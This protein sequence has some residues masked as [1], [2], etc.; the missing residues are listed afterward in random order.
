MRFLIATILIGISLS[1][2]ASELTAVKT[3]SIYKAFTPEEKVNHIVWLQVDGDQGLGALDAQDLRKYGGVYLSRPFQPFEEYIFNRGF[4][5]ALAVQLD[6]N[7]NPSPGD[8]ENLPTLNTLSSIRD[9]NLLHEYF[10]F[11]KVISKSFGISH[12]VLPLAKDTVS[13]HGRLMAKMEAHDPD[14]FISP[15]RLEFDLIKKKKEFKSLF[16]GADF[17]VLSGEELSRAEKAIR[18]HAEHANF[19]RA[20]NTIKS[21]ITIKYSSHDQLVKRKLPNKLAVEISRASIVPL[22]R[23]PGI[24]PLSSDTL[25]L[26]TDDPAGF[27][28]KMLA[29][30]AYLITS[31]SGIR[32]SH[33]PVI[34]DNQYFSQNLN[35]FEGR[36]IIY[37]GGFT[38]GIKY[39]DEIDA[40]LFT[41]VENE[42]YSYLL[43]QLLFGSADATGIM[44]MAVSKLASYSNEPITGKR[45][46]GYAP[47]E[48]SGLTKISR[49]E[50][51]SIV[52]EAIET[53]STPGCQIAVAIDGSIVLEEGY[54]YLTYDS[55]IR[56][57]KNT[58]Y[59]LASVT[60]VM[61][62]LL[63]VMKLYEDN[64]INLDADLSTYL[65]QYAGS[66]K[67]DITIRQILSHNAGLISYVPFW[68]RALGGAD[69]M[70]TF[71][72]ETEEDELNDK[73][74]YGMKPTP[75]L[76]DSLKNWIVSSPVLDYDSVPQYRYSDIG[77]MILHQVVEAITSEPME[78]YLT[79]NFYSKLGLS[80]LGFNPREKGVNLFEVAPTEYDY[81]FREE[82]VWGEVHDRNA[83]VFGGVAGHAGL[84][85]NSHDLLVLLQMIAQNGE[86]DGEQLLKPSTIHYFNDQYFPGNR[87]A[88]GWDKKG[89]KV[90][91]ASENA[92]FSSFGHTGFTGTLVWVDPEFDLVFVFLSNRIYPNANNY[93]LIQKDIRTRVQDVVYE[94]IL[95]KWIN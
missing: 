17:W 57:D 63:A 86:Y 11:L 74:S 9:E 61:G 67:S 52:Q 41:S 70:E 76:R 1:S 93:K 75:A 33:A 26:V 40:A 87:R 49:E 84:F 43:P 46:L 7:L 94:A 71:Y 21:S 12:L 20:E 23:Q 16:E 15:S 56:A 59:D 79:T 82:Q 8:L 73:R 13:A 69:M 28:A 88:L 37:L 29:R 58:M 68:K 36:S 95:S 72:Y 4:I 55:L 42:L 3:D 14:Y 39:G 6:E 81:Y 92:S 18:K 60:K 62:T 10:G 25:C 32:Q 22:Q 90:S 45:I 38:E 30:Y 89:D 27:M 80:R 2:W 85:S 66:N 64:L 5:P 24:L 51:R 47:P 78:H 91:N 35:D 50:I 83:A 31:P 44:P 34:I 48:I 19:D 65:P 54:G 77:F 53:G